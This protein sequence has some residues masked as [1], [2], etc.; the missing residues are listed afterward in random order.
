M[1]GH[2]TAERRSLAYHRAIANRLGD[3]PSILE[4]A[5]RRVVEWCETR[6]VHP[7]YADAWRSLL[8]RSVTKIAEAIVDDSEH[9]T[10]LRQVSPFAGSLDA[11]TRWQLWRSVG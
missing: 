10:A 2:R 4:A 8:D 9:M 1:D 11:R 3:E 6:S 7:R 5:R